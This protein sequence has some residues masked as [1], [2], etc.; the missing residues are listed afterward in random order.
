[1]WGRGGGI[2]TAIPAFQGEWK[3]HLWKYY[4]ARIQQLTARLMIERQG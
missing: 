3:I 4:Q 1:M 2:S